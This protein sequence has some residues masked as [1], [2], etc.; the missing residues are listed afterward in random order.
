MAVEFLSPYEAGKVLEGVLPANKTVRPNWLQ[1]H[2]G[3]VRTSESRTINFDQEFSTKNT[4]GM[5]VAPHSDVTPITL[6][7]FGHKEL[8]FGYAKEGLNSPDYEEISTR[9]LGQPL[10]GPIDVMANELADIRAKLAKAEQRFENLFEYIAAQI[11]F[12]GSY[13]AVSEKHPLVAYDFGRT[14]VTTDA[15]YLAGNVPSIDLTTLVGNGGAGKRAWDST[16][17]TAAPT[18]VKDVIKMAST[19]YIRA[20]VSVC[21]MSSDAYEL[22]EDDITTNYA[23]AANLTTAVLGRVELKILPMV[24]AYQSLNYR[25]TF[26]LG[27]GKFVD[28]YT[29]DAIYHDRTTGVATP[30]VPDGYVVMIPPSSYG[31]KVYGRIMHPRAQYAA[32]PRWMNVWEDNKTGKREWEIHTSFIMG[33]TDIDSVVSWKVM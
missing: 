29:Y 9:Q 31:A 11:L 22:F 13:S 21:L 27:N 5:F 2:F 24:E 14:V 6:E 32:M 4:M 15:G 19:A 17:G 18:P 12:Y 30:Y 1:T 25:R 10:N 33:H 7:N 16:G 26:P 23:T 28:I 3:Q 20:G 8:T